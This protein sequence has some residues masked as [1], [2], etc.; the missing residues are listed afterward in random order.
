VRA[1]AG[2]RGSPGFIQPVANQLTDIC[3]R[4]CWRMTLAGIGGKPSNAKVDVLNTRRIFVVASAIEDFVPR[5]MPRMSTP[6]PR[7]ID[8]GIIAA[9][10]AVP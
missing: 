7:P 9:T 5:V 1:F 6:T 10:L 4:I 8:Y 2:V 3:R